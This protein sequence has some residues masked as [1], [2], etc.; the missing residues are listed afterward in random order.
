MQK[1]IQEMY[2][3]VEKLEEQIKA[4]QE[5]LNI[6]APYVIESRRKLDD[7]GDDRYNYDLSKQNRISKAQKINKTGAL[8]EPIEITDWL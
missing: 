7:I 4:Q 3:R 6:L 1:K 2:E 8:S 5:L